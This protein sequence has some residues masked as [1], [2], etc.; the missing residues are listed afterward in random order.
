MDLL[1]LRPTELG[2]LHPMRKT[3]TESELIASLQSED[4]CALNYLYANYLSPLR[5]IVT[6]IVRS[7]EAASDVIQETFV[8]IWKNICRYD[9]SKGTL[10]TW[11]LNIERN[12]AIDKRRADLSLGKAGTIYLSDIGEVEIFQY[13]I[14][15]VE[16]DVRHFV[17]LLPEN[18]RIAIELIYFQ[19]YSFED[20]ADHLAVP[21]G[22]GCDIKDRGA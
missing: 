14:T 16:M 21:L 5:N 4:R 10:F 19:G 6:K 13:N 18:R 9:T 1:R 20:A 11:I 2:R 17:M 15:F 7:E 22:T 8:K 3:Y 12:T